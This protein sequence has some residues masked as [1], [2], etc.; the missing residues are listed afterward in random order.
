MAQPFDSGSAQ[1]SG[2]VFPVA[3]G[4]SLTTNINYAPVTVSETGILLYQSGSSGGPQLA[5]YDRSG[6]LLSTVGTSGLFVAFPAISLDEKMIAYMHS[7]GLGGDIWLRDLALGTDIRLTS[8]A[9]AN[10][11]PV[12]SPK[13]D[14]IVFQS[15]RGGRPGDLYQRAASGSGQDEPVSDDSQPEGGKSMDAGWPVHR[16]FGDRSENEVRSLGSAACGGRVS[17]QARAVLAN[18]VQ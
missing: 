13:G 9:S 5:W 8:D 1:A 10:R 16:L 18:G 2:D 15:S 3:E 7:S 6:K 12:W 14:R 4:V 17:G 11:D